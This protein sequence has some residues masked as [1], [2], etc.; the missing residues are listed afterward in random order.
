MV[1]VIDNGTPQLSDRELLVRIDTKLDG[2]IEEKKDHEARIRRMEEASSSYATQAQ[3]TVIEAQAQQS[4]TK[5]QL[6]GGLVGVF[7]AAGSAV[8]VIQWIIHR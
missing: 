6:W 7:G 1:S 3:V 5:K 8:P 2:V 4:V